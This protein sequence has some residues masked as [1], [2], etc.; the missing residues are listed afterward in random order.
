MLLF[1]LPHS[2]VFVLILSD[3]LIDESE[4]LPLK[5]IPE[6]KHFMPVPYRNQYQY[7]FT[8]INNM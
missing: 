5:I 4:N 2:F 3:L 1:Y 8:F 7:N 6:P